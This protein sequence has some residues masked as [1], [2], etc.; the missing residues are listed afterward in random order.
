MVDEIN[1]I[2]SSSKMF[3][4]LRPVWMTVAWQSAYKTLGWCVWV[5]VCVI[6]A[7]FHIHTGVQW[8]LKCL[9]RS[10]RRLLRRSP[11]EST[12]KQTTNSGRR[13]RD[14]G[15]NHTCRKQSRANGGVKW[16][17]KRCIIIPPSP[18]PSPSCY[19]A[20]RS[21]CLSVSYEFWCLSVCKKPNEISDTA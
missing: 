12:Q 9:S 6:A 11:R 19:F 3:V 13:K 7:G 2:I 18:P 4:D 17:H 15:K 8:S 16:R 5:Y 1:C 14:K 21:A 20:C 10:R